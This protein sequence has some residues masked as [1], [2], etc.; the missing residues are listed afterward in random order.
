MRKNRLRSFI[1][2]HRENHDIE[3]NLG[4]HLHDE[5]KNEE[6]NLSPLKPQQLNF[7]STSGSSHATPIQNLLTPSSPTLPLYLYHLKLHNH[8]Q[9]HN[10]H[11][12]TQ[13]LVLLMWFTSL[14]FSDGRVL[15]LTRM[16]PNLNSLVVRIVYLPLQSQRYL[17]P[18][19][20]KMPLHGIYRN[21]LS[22][23]GM[24]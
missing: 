7:G 12:L 20:R 4:N 5:N 14:I 21:L 6:E 11:R 24:H 3:P 1:N 13:I 23:I 8:H 9:W 18:L 19:C 2:L 16:L 15:I 10:H 22:R 17:L